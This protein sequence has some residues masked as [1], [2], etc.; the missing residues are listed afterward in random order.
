[1]T[2]ADLCKQILALTATVYRPITLK[3]LASL[4][5]RLQDISDN[6]ESLRVIVTSCGSFLTIRDDI[7]Y[8]VHQSAKDFLVS[9]TIFPSQSEQAHYTI[10]SRSLLIT[11]KTLRRDIYGL[12]AL[13]YPIE[14]VAQPDPDP[15]AVSRYACIYWID[16]LCLCD[17]N[18]SSS[19]N[20]K[21]L[22]DGGILDRFLR[23]KYLYWLEALSLCKSMSKGVLSM[24][25]LETLMQ[26]IIRN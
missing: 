17:W 1:L 4:V 24:T 9:N 20:Y 12:G 11:S 5:E 8:F 6:S 2:D 14:Q 16:H 7:I 19:E 23:E 15:L 13:G 10:F 3:E 21:D 25:K 26:V 22:Q 18:P